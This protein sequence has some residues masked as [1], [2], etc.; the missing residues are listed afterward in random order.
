MEKQ[1]E[2]DKDGKSN[3]VGHPQLLLVDVGQHIKNYR[4]VFLT[5]LPLK[6]L[7]ASR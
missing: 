7:S 2:G 1:G 6:I 5:A 4:V 3:E